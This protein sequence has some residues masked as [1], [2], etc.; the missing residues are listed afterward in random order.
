MSIHGAIVLALTTAPPIDP[1]GP[2]VRY[3]RDIRPILSDRCFQCH[4]PDASTRAADLRLDTFEL[5]TASRDGAAGAIVPGDAEA[6]L[7]WQRVSTHD[8]DDRMPPASSSKRALSDAEKALIHQWIE[9]GAEYEPHWSFVPPTRREAPS[10]QGDDWPIGEIDRFIRAEQQRAGLEPSPDE[11]PE[12][13]LRRLFLDLTGLPPTPEEVDEYLA[14]LRTDRFERWV[15]RL[16]TEEP[17][18]TRTAERLATPWLDAARYGDTNG[19]HTD[20]GRQIWPWRDWVLHALR[21]NMPFDQFVTE[22]LAGDLLENATESQ[23]I[24]SGFHRNHVATDEGGAIAEEYLVEYAV[25]RVSTTGA[26]F[27]GLTLG[28]AR[29]HDHKFD[30]ITMEDFY[31]LAAYFNSVEEPGLYSQ[32]PDP[33]RA[34]EPFMSVPTAGQRKQLEAIEND[35]AQAKRELETRS[36]ED[37]AQQAEFFAQFAKESGLAWAPVRITGGRTDGN[38]EVVL[39]ED[40]SAVFRGP[41][42]PRDVT[43]LTL[44]TDATDLRLL[45]LEALPAGA[46]GTG[47]AGRANNGNAVVTGISA[48]IVSRT[49]PAQKKAL[50]FDWAWA[51]H[52]QQNGDFDIS[53]VLTGSDGTGWALES[54]M[55]PGGRV[56]MLLSD[57]PF[58]YDGGSEITFRIEQNSIY[59]QH[60]IAR[61]RFAA[62]RFNEQGLARLPLAMSRWQIAG[63]F[64][65]TSGAQG[66]QTTFG[67]EEGEALDFSRNF[68]FGN[69]YWRFDG[70][71][72]DGQ[73]VVL[74]QGVHVLYVGRHIYAPVARPLDISLGTDDGFQLFLNG[75]KIAER[76]VD[77]SVAPDQDRVTLPLRAGVNALVVKIVNS[78]GEAGF[79]FRGTALESEFGGDLPLALLPADARRGEADARRVDDAWRMAFLPRFKELRQTIAQR[80]AAKAEVEKNVPRTMVMKE[81][82]VPRDT[83]VLMR[84][85][86]DQPDGTR[87]VGRTVPIALGALPEGAPADRRGLAQWLIDDRNPLVARVTVNRLWELLFGT[88][89][90]RTSEDFGLQGEWPS[91]PELLDWLAVE[92]RESG[93]DLHHMLRL[94]V[95][96]G[97][98]RQSSSIREDARRVDPEN[99]L[100][101]AY[102]R[103]R[104]AAEQIRDQALFTSGLLVERL[105]GPSVRPYQPDGLWQE[106][107]MLASNTRVYERGQGEDL[108]RRSLYTYWKRACPPASLLTFDAPTREFCTVRRLTTNTP[109]QALALWNDEQMVEAART[110]AA[111]TLLGSGDD[112]GRLLSLFRRCTA[113]TPTPRELA[114]LRDALESARARYMGAPEDADRLLAV[115]IAPI[116]PSLHRGELAAWT[117]VS[118]AMLSLYEVTT[119]E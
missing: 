60:N 106:V 7:L 87:R 80:E 76:V 24:A 12:R 28:C 58:G 26:V 70:R 55:R 5:A 54:H 25:D 44:E 74:A 97:T 48:E 69:Q 67:P 112:D 103:R 89:I 104:L 9:A 105:G 59:D 42:P 22:Q 88:G 79:Y 52:S 35:I 53:N 77:R 98:Y 40:G 119:Q 47:A 51:D 11:A 21:D 29:C 86:Y 43:T 27:L 8:L 83:F 56:A 34:F 66:Y 16:L 4:G 13:L 85:Q 46:D 114:L 2:L 108:W 91:H 102:P 96:S 14:D 68:G 19:I 10:I 15:D 93:W 36:P 41:N 39:D 90:V 72:I 92:F 45:L 31:G 61:V 3:G 23:K 78:G 115:G 81:L 37:D 107:S 116:D 62:A 109:L 50:R 63:P 65:T 32:L 73:A 117:M 84:G 38:A 30:P 57:E 118:S 100:L 75:Q 113:R 99:R 33:N 49:D 64:E 71:L 17:Y 95:T 18:R 20:A 110:L 1:A 101:A 82:A 6:S 94:M 111:R